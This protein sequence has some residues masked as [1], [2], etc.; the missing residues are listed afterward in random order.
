MAIASVAT[1][2]VPG[3]AST[4]SSG[5]WQNQAAAS[6]AREVALSRM[7]A[8]Y[9]IIGMIFMML[10][11]TFMG[12]WNLLSISSRHAPGSLS[13]G[14]IQAHGHAQIFGW[15]ATF[16]MGIGFYS[17]PKLRKGAPLALAKAW[18][19]LVLWTL[20]AGLRWGAGSYGWNWRLLLPLSALLELVAFLIFF[21]S[22]AG[23]RPEK[24][25]TASAPL[26]PPEPGHRG[27]LDPWIMV[28]VAGTIGLL[29]ALVLN[30]VECSRLALS[31]VS[32]AF[33]A[34]FDLRF[35]TVCTWGFL[36][37]F[38]WG[39]TSRWM[40]AFLGLKPSSTRLLFT[41]LFFTTSGVVLSL[42]GAP[43]FSAALL[44]C[45]TTLSLM[46]LRLFNRTHHAA[47]T[48]GVSPAFPAFVRIAFVWSIV[49]AVLGIWA[50]LSS[51]AHGIAGASRHAL[52]VG[53]IAM[54]VFSVGPRVLPAFSGLRVLFSP[55]LMSAALVLLAVGCAIRVSSEIVAYQGYAQWGW[56]LLPVSAI[57]EMT[58]VTLF[59]LNMAVTLAR[60]PLVPAA[61]VRRPSA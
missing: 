53:F 34:E 51:Q 59:A 12:V 37:P 3:T 42:L 1:D 61:A 5:V 9:I 50:S 22:V 58:A 13:P 38:V 52:T 44:L 7:L 60:A 26:S 56:N 57:I 30:L 17:I 18:M 35:L 36:V 55:A 31:G 19:C 8:A 27:R 11:G 46:A 2:V 29:L 40:P 4:S 10:P 23:H 14:W 15:V 54:M 48:R 33:P 21:T 43:R 39:F 28:V 45:G 20:G 47:K 41:A 6:A 49:A 32:P 24:R 16:I 25:E